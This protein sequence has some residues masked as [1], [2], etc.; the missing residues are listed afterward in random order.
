[1]L[2][3]GK[4]QSGPGRQVPGDSGRRESFYRGGQG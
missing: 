1:M 3:A 2:K 4:D